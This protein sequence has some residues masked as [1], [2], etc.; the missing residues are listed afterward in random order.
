MID[1]P[2]CRA[3]RRIGYGLFAFLKIFSLREEVGGLKVSADLIGVSPRQPVHDVQNH[4]LC[5]SACTGL[6]HEMIRTRM[7]DALQ[8]KRDFLS[9]AL[10]A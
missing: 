5:N 1:F 9:P 7:T 6:E 8:G 10:R 3:L 2:G 4:Q